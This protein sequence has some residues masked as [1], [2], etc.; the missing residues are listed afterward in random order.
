MVRIVL[1]VIDECLGAFV[2][3]QQGYKNNAIKQALLLI[4]GQNYST[5]LSKLIVH[6]LIVCS[7]YLKFD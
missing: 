3:I 6:S 7:I 5:H 1:G 4:C 2:N